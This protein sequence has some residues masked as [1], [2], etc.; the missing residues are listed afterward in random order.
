MAQGQLADFVGQNQLIF[1]VGAP[2][3]LLDTGCT[4][5]IVFFIYFGA[6][7]SQILVARLLCGLHVSVLASV[8]HDSLVR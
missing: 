4:I 6:I 7:I 3:R 2:F 5:E 8:S 1:L